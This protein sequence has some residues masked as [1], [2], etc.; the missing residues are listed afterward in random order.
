MRNLQSYFHRRKIKDIP[1]WLDNLGIRSM[2]SFKS[3][4]EA[5]EISF[6]EL[7]MSKYF[8]DQPATQSK[9]QSNA[10]E[11]AESSDTWHVPAAERPIKKTPSSTR[12]NT[13]KAAPKPKPAKKR[14]SKKD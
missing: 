8:E 4:C 1:A 13:R 9:E 11:K 12:P 5:E 2:E 6:N 14:A 10:K 3:F 7:D